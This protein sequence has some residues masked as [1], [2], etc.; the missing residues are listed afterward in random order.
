TDDVDHARI[1]WA[2]LASDRLPEGFRAEL[3]RALPTLVRIARNA[4]LARA[5]DHDDA[6]PRGHGCLSGARVREAVD[7]ALRDLVLPGVEH[8]GI[9]TGDARKILETR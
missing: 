6:A 9:A 1:G 5:T 4:W 8:F 7:E 3:E 2:L